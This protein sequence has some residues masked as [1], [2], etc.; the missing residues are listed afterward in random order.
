MTTLVTGATGALGS[1]VMQLLSR[2]AGL[3]VVVLESDRRLHRAHGSER[4]IDADRLVHLTAG[5]HDTLALRGANALRVT[6]QVL[7]DPAA[8]RVTH[9]VLLSSAMVYGAW[10]NNPVPLTEEAPLR[11]DVSFGFA[12][13]LAQVEQ[14]VDAWRLS[15]PGRSVTILRPVLTLAAD[16]TSSVVRAL[17]AGIGARLDED[18]PPAQFLHFDDLASA[19]ALGHDD[20]LDGVFNVAPD[21][22]VA[23]ETVRALAGTP[24]RIRLPAWLIEPA[25]DLRWR[26]QRGPI[27]PGLWPFAQHPWLVANDRLKAVG[28]RP[29][30]TN[31]QAYV[32]GTEARWWTMLTP[33]RK[34]ELALGGMVGAVVAAAAGGLK[35]AQRAR[36]RRMSV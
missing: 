36:R 18:D 8:A 12:H 27:P 7:A 1:R 29:T 25:V 31:E 33:Q 32:E 30:V 22:W 17:A 9:L 19:V 3:D 11:A 14:M 15:V 21:G 26:F 20:R 16:G 4:H 24:P 28:W 23:G 6:E 5:D 2:Q 13:Q 34:Q 35:A 10:P